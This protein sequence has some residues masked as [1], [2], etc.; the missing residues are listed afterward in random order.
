M[1]HK[2]RQALRYGFFA[3]VLSA[4]FLMIKGWKIIA[5]R[6]R[7]RCGEI[8]IIAR[9]NN[10]VIFVEVKARKNFQNA[11]FAVSNKNC[12]RIR[13]ASK[14]WIAQQTNYQLLSYQYDIIAVAPWRLPRHLPNAF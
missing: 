10:F 7:N 8:D 4:I 14:I 3:E 13:A 1:S 9:R 2:R 6:Y 12:K 5:L 11:I